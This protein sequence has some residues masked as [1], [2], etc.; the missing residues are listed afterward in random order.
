MISEKTVEENILKKAKQKRL[1]GDVAIEGG[2][3]TTAFF[4]KDTLHDLFG[5]VDTGAKKMESEKAPET[6][7]SSEERKTPVPEESNKVLVE[8]EQALGTAEEDNDV[9][10]AKTARA[11]AAAEYAEF[12]ESIPLDID[13]EKGEEKSPVEDELDKIIEQVF[14]KDYL[15]SLIY[16]F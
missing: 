13:G 11:E 3:F 14:R 4:K 9:A 15:I 8:L 10:A 5:D 2:N 1:L 16:P 12:D 7:I 6:T